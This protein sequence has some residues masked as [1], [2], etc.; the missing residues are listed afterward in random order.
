MTP[1]QAVRRKSWSYALIGAGIACFVMAYQY[2]LPVTGRGE[3]PPEF[4][5]Y[6]FAGLG[7]LFLIVGGILALKMRKVPAAAVATDLSGPRGTA[8]IG[9]SAAGFVALAGSYFV[10]YL[11]PHDEILAM[12]LSTGL[13]VI[14]IICFVIASRIAKKIR[15]DAAT[16][17]AAKE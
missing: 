15:R 16:T 6:L 14:M 10:G 1:E 17:G 3:P 11:V 4:A 7:V 5:P 12:I 9:W 8:V 2:A 13:L